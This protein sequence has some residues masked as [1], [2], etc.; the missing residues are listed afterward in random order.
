M[1]S[2][3]EEAPGH[4]HHQPVQAVGQAAV[5]GGAVLEG[6]NQMA[7]PL[8][9]VLVGEAPGPGKPL[10]CISGVVDSDGAA[11]QLACR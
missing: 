1:T 8:L 3:M 4:E 10:V 7:K 6:V 2:R 9:D 11:A 5:G